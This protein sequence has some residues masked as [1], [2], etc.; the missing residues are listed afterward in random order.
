M[1][2]REKKYHWR[3]SRIGRMVR[4]NYKKVLASYVSIGAAGS[5]IWKDEN[6]DIQVKILSIGECLELITKE[7]LG[8]PIP[9]E[10]IISKEEF[11]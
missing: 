10:Y 9:S 7:A 8:E 11:I 5:R 6:G 3:K 4:E 1:T 2:K